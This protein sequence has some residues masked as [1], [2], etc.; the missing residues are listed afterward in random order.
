MTLAFITAANPTSPLGL[1]TDCDMHL[2]ILSSRCRQ[3]LLFMCVWLRQ[4][5]H[6]ALWFYIRCVRYTGAVT[7]PHVS[8]PAPCSTFNE[9]HLDKGDFSLCRSLP[10]SAG[11]SRDWFRQ[12]ESPLGDTSNSSSSLT[13]LVS[14]HVQTEPDPT[15]AAP[16]TARWGWADPAAAVP[17]TGPRRPRVVNACYYVLV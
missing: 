16:H 2:E 14:F 6:V 15:R 5:F 8:V 3:Q 12:Q 13:A 11:V 4:C 7:E 17:G 1:L 10:L 9:Q